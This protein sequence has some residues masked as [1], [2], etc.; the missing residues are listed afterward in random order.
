MKIGFDI[1]ENTDEQV[2]PE[3]GYAESSDSGEK[4]SSWDHF[5]NAVHHFVEAIRHIVNLLRNN[6]EATGQ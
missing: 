1:G 4:D 6:K 5:H 3:V 2:E